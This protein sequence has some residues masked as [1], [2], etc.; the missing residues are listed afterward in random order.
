MS[1]LLGRRR[2]LVGVVSALV[3]AIAVVAVGAAYAEQP[4]KVTVGNLEFEANGGLT[5]KALSKT[6][7]TPVTF[8]ASGK[9]T[10]VDGTHPP[11]IKEVIV[12]GDKNV[13]VT[14]KGYPTCSSGK[15]QS[16]DT[17][18]ALAA[19]K[20]ALIGEGTT[21]VEIQFPEQPPIQTKS[22]LLIFNGGE[23]GGVTTMYVHAYIT[24]PT[25][26]AI[27][28]TVKIKKIHKGRFGLLAV[29]TIPKIAGGAGSV[30]DF[31]FKINKQF[32]YLGKKQSVISA[33]C[34][35]GKLQANVTSKFSDG[36]LAKAEIIR[37]CTP[38][39]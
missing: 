22:R 21:G 4:V 17:D 28:T 29:A 37:S 19:C 6:T 26:A 23:S 39:G 10:T 8:E 27:V 30:T 34:T 5:P 12:E 35:D 25:P 13:F 3:M 2:R 24:V 36:T 11:A 15:L 9:I 38:K 31:K 1:G 33:I 20:S 14:T 7:P 18:A 16:R 32:T